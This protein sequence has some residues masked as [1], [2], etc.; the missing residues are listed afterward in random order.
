MRQCEVFLHGI[1]AGVLTE[2]DDMEFT[3]VYDKAYLLSDKCQAVSLTLPLRTDPY[4][5]PYLF[6]AF[7][8]MLSEG[9]NCQIQLQLL[10]IDADDDF[11]LLL[12]TCQF[13][14]IGATTIK[15][16]AS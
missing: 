11:G 16:I 2:K 10:H 1:K 15:P 14:T 13:D 9:D 6:S 8:N 3:F 5:S 4:Q 7:A 12:A